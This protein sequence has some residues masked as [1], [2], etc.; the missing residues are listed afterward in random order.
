MVG[1]VVLIPG[2]VE[3]KRVLKETRDFFRRHGLRAAQRLEPGW[4]KQNLTPQLRSEP[5]LEVD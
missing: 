4:D 3:E 2:S 5:A 1:H